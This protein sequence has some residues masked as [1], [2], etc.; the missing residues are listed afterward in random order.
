MQ[1]SRFIRRLT[2]ASC[3]ALAIAGCQP[4]S[5]L[6]SD[7][8]RGDARAEQLARHGDHAGAA[9][10]L[11]EAATQSSAARA[12]GL[13]L[14]ASREWLQAG[15]TVAAQRTLARL[16][17]PLSVA[18]AQEQARLSAELAILGGQPQRALELLAAASAAEDPAVLATR[19]RALF[20]LGRT[21]DAVHALMAR[22]ELLRGPEERLENQRLIVESAAAAA[23]RGHDLRPPP[24]VDTQ[25]AGWLELG[26]IR[27][28]AAV[29]PLGTAGRLQAW[30]ARY[31][32]HPA[33]AGLWREL[34]D[35]YATQLPDTTQI[36][37]L[38]PLSG[39]TAVAGQ[40]VRDGFLTAYYEQPQGTRPVVKVYDV[41]TSDAASAYLAA[42]G[43]GA[44]VIVG[45]LTREE[46][47]N[48][49]S[50]A[51]GRATTLALNYLQDGEVAPRRFYQFA[52]SPEDEARQ[53]ARRALADGRASGLALVPA[54]DWGQRVLLAFADEL[55][56]G[57]GTLLAQRTYP[58]GIADFQDLLTPLLDLRPG[59]VGAGGR[60]APTYRPDAQFIFVAAQPVTGRMIRAQLRFNH[61][62]RLPVYATS[63]VF[64][65]G[66]RGNTD[67]EGIIFP[68]MPWVLAGAGSPVAIVRD[69]ADRVWPGRS[70][71]RSR[72]FAFGYDAFAVV[73]ELGR[74]R[75]PFSNPVTGMTGRL[76]LDL[77]G[78]VRRD[79][80]FAQ[81]SGGEP[82]PLDMR[83]PTR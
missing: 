48:L 58:S 71:S 53:A 60:S 55:Q 43:D 76:G 41:A 46:V 62:T 75:A 44:Q 8:G 30:R 38:L 2:A 14:A 20:A 51:D 6:R 23:A 33:N 40:A 16:T 63:D 26:Q 10:A 64:E 65:P 47:A 29:S 50:M 36:G 39:R 81:I 31:P 24:G 32:A 19:A 9:R 77:D 37:L 25:L 69:E 73:A 57:G 15:N 17:S 82:R 34:L 61:A 74:R 70:P 35:T 18:D 59:P 66:S 7:G 22:G 49:A 54:T 27:A 3:L 67:L 80:D 52:L 79:L 5:V 72:L 45:P 68:D 28:S 4:L 11:E 21:A 12:N 1:A 83:S 42:V 78:R 56:R 13:W